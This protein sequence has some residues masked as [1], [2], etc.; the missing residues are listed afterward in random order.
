MCLRDMDAAGVEAER[1]EASAQAEGSPSG[2]EAG[3]THQWLNAICRAVFKRLTNC[4]F[5]APMADAES[6]N[7]PGW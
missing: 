2:S 4:R 7:F 1:S 5:D 3:T 6:L